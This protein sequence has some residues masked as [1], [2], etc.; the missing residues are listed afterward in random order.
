MIQLLMATLFGRKVLVYF[1]K[2]KDSTRVFS[3][4]YYR[5]R[6]LPREGEIFWPVLDIE[7]SK[8]PVIQWKVHEVRH[9][10]GKCCDISVAPKV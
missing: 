5:M 9:I 8:E 6:F 7:S 4:K 2:E 1:Y 3:E 10:P